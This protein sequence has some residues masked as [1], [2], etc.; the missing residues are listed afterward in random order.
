MKNWDDAFKDKYPLR[1]HM[2]PAERLSLIAL[3][4]ALRP[5]ISI[6]VGTAQGGSLQ[7]LAE[8][9]KRVY[10]LDLEQPQG[11]TPFPNVEHITGDSHETLPALLA[12]LERFDFALIDGDHSCNG[13][14]RDIEALGGRA[15]RHALRRHRENARLVG[16]E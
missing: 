13:V 9:S 1:W 12:R 16:G 15:T 5:N 4:D 3:I 8:Y 2:A 6:E 10:A 14:R 7:V 11:V